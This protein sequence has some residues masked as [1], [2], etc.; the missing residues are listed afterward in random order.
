MEASASAQLS[1]CRI[2]SEV[3]L[4][5]DPLEPISKGHNEKREAVEIFIDRVDVTYGR[6]GGLNP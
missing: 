2:P 4:Q 6:R 5:G 1:L 3:Q